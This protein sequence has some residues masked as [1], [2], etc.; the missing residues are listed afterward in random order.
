MN[1]FQY[2]TINEKGSFVGGKPTKFYQGHVIAAADVLPEAFR[3]LQETEAENGIRIKEFR[4][5][6]S[7]TTGKNDRFRSAVGNPSGKRRGPNAWYCYVLRDGTVTK[8]RFYTSYK[9]NPSRIPDVSCALCGPMACLSALSGF[10]LEDLEKRTY[11]KKQ[12]SILDKI[13][14]VFTRQK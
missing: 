3:K 4:F 6:A 10:S 14:S 11:A 7:E 12:T 1:H 9:K 2:L 13:K 8:W 5:M